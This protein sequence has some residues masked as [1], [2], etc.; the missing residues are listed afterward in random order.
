MPLP[1]FPSETL[2][3]LLLAL[4]CALAAAW[5]AALLRARGVRPVR[6]LAALLGRQPRAGRALLA[7]ILAGLWIVAG[8]KPGGAIRRASARAPAAPAVPA[9]AARALAEEDFRRGFVLARVGTG[10]AFDFSAPSN[11]AV[12]ADW[13]AFGAAEDWIY[14]AFTNWSFRAGT[15]EASRLRVRS[16]GWAEPLAARGAAPGLWLAPLRASLGVVPR[17]NWGRLAASARPSRFWHLLT[18]SNTLQLTWQN[19]LLG[20]AA[21]APVSFQAE[22][23]PS[24]RFTYRYGLSRT[25]AAASSGVL[26]GASLGGG[27]WTTNALAAGVTSLAF[28]PLS[29]ADARDPDPDGDGLATADELF[30]HGTDP[31]DPDTDLDGLTDYEELFVH[32]TDPL[33]PRSNGGPYGDGLAAGLGGRDP[34][35]RPPGSTNAVLEHVFYS[36]TADGAFVRPQPTAREA[37]LRVSVSGS[38]AGD[39][40]VGRRVV[41]L[42]ARAGAPSPALLVP[43]ARGESHR[44]FL[45]GG[46]GLAVSLGS[47]DFAFGALPAPGAPGRLHFPRVEAAEPCI[48]DY[49]ARRTRVALPAGRGEELLSCTW[50]GGGGVAVENLPPRA[51]ELTGRFPAR[52]TR[53]V[54]YALSHPDYLFGRT[55]YGQSVR[56]CPKPP[57]PDPEEPDPPWYSGGGDGSEGDGDDRE[58]HLCCHG[59][60]CGARCLCGCGVPEDPSGGGGGEGGGDGGEACRAHGVPPADCAPLHEADYT[61]AVRRFPP[62][63]GVLLLREPPL[64]E[65][66]RLDVPAEGR[67]CCP[68]PEHRTNHVGVA[69]LSR[70]LRL[71]GADGRDFERAERPCDVFVAGVS[72]SAAPGDASVAFCRG[73]EICLRRDRTV[74]GVAVRGGP[75]VDLAACNA[76]DAGFGLP[77][78]VCADAWRA[79]ALRLAADVALPGGR[80]RLALEGATGPF[81]AWRFDRDAGAFRRLLDAEAA[82]DVDLPMSAWRELARRAAGDGAADLPVRVTSSAPGSVRLVVRYWNVVGGRFVQDEAAQRITAVLPPLRLDVSRDGRVDGGAAAAWLDGR[83][84]Y[85]WVN[86]DTIKGDYIGASDNHA[87]NK[88]DLVVNGT[89]DRINFFPVALD[90]SKFSA[91]WG[92]RATYE[93]KPASGNAESFN[94]CLAD[95][96][97]NAAGSVQTTNATTLSGQPLS[98]AS[99]VALPAGGVELPQSTISRFS[100]DSGLMVCEAKSSYESLL[101]EIKVDGRPLYS[102]SVPMTILPVKQMY[103]WINT[104]HLSG[105]CVIRPSSASRLWDE[106][107]TKALVFLHGANVDESQAEAWGDILFKRLWVSGV[108]ADFYNVDWR[109][110]IGGAAN[111]HENASNAFAVARCLAPIL[112]DISQDKIIVAHSLGNMVVSSMIQDHGLRV[113]KY[114]MCNSAVPAEAYD[115]SLSPIDVLVHSDWNGYPRRSFANE[116]Y[117]LFLGNGDDDRRLLTWGGRFA[118]VADHAVNFYSTG[119]HVL[120]LERNNNVWAADGYE[121]WDQKFERYAWHKQELWK[122]RRG[123]LA[124]LG[125]TDWAGW[126]IREN[127][128]G[129]NMIQATNAWLMGE[130]EL[131]TNTVFAIHPEGMNTKAIPQSLRDA[132]LAKGIPSRTAASGATRWGAMTMGRAMYDLN[133]TETEQNGIPR[134]NG[135][136]VRKFGWLMSTTWRDKWLH[137][138]MKDV[139]YFYVFKF[140]EKLKEVGGLE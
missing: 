123:L 13:E 96:P 131:K 19:V 14:L 44:A 100:E 29:A 41:P 97:W 26:A 50:R 55:V 6:A 53:A 42:V 84:F 20:R 31:H 49:A 33:S 45:R 52:E 65:K 56:F 12:C 2:A 70:R 122:G 105:D 17:A 88:D 69:Y 47:D 101:M 92:G 3:S 66:V 110:N 103:N 67:R 126:G 76:L 77:M 18:P 107:N 36:G 87:F 128:L 75:G 139:A 124:R 140:F 93:I 133:T 80:V 59:G 130:D 28:W 22:L 83:T 116:W 43:L 120:E 86:E 125:T 51:A 62:L 111:Y 34:L 10:E 48:H 136:P 30:V 78:T 11:A 137:S 5:L 74:L 121:N 89:F 82:P 37:V 8:A 25:A 1:L 68:C 90:L 112:S 117:R 54:S 64:Y 81:A 135:W 114:I 32:G 61:N 15:D 40:V 72:P 58:E 73:G 9:A 94:F 98:S 91:A 57:D 108:H 4:A 109:S 21:D 99:L 63:G 79:P 119:D 138:D 134:P 132:I 115:V 27:A 118:D 23:W 39:L 46:E 127:L 104:R 95:I 35:S 71:V 113:L 38:G 7:A 85:H 60:A 16:D 102:Y 129:Y 106:R 24:G